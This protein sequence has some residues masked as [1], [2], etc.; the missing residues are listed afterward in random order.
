MNKY[1]MKPEFLLFLS[2]HVISNTIEYMNLS[3]HFIV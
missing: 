1:D 2:M 3:Q